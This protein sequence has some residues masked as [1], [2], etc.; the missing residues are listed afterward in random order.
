[1]RSLRT[2]T[3]KTSLIYG[4]WSVL[5]I[6][7]QLQLSFLEWLTPGGGEPLVQTTL[8]LSW[9]TLE[10]LGEP[11]TMPEEDQQKKFVYLTILT[12]FLGRLIS[13]LQCGKVWFRVSNMKLIQEVHYDTYTTKIHRVLS[14]MFLP[15]LELSWCQL[16]PC[17][18]RPGPESTMATSWLNMTATSDPH[19][20]A[21]TSI[22]KWFQ[23]KAVIHILH[24]FTIQ[25][26]IAMASRV[27]R[28]KMVASSHVL[29]AQSD[30]FCCIYCIHVP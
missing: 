4:I 21:L 18:H 14:V 28:M 1:M 30:Q 3:C 25:L 6:N 26:L 7:D 27:H 29:C 16:K 17:V 22:Q 19:T 11:T 20:P 5:I 10:E 9:S 2:F 13:L 8:R 12:I 15:E 23:G 24:L